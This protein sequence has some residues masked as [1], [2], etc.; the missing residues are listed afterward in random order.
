[1]ETK[2]VRVLHSGRTRSEEHTSQKM[3]A[4][5]LDDESNLSS[6]NSRFIDRS[7]E[8]IASRFCVE[9]GV[10]IADFGC[11]PGLYS[12]RLAKPGAYV[13]GSRARVTQVLRRMN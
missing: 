3:L 8:W 2:A 9:E 6:R 12:N 1:M 4:Y 11:G 10:K 5:H 7:V 13:T